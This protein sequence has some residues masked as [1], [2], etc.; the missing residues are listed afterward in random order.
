LRVSTERQERK[1]ESLLTQASQVEQ[2]VASLGGT[3]VKRYAGQEHATEGY[4]RALLDRLLSDAQKVPRVFDAVIVADATRWSRDNVRSDTGLE[5]LRD[6]GVKFFVL[7]TEYDLHNP[8]ARMFLRLTATIGG[9]H[10]AMQRKKSLENRIARAKRGL[11]TVGRLPYGRLFD[12][13]SQTWSLDPAKQALV[14][15]AARRYL[16]GEALPRLVD[17]VGLSQSRLYRLLGH[18][19]GDSW[20]LSFADKT[21]AIEEQVMLTIPPLLD[22][23][24]LRAVQQRLQANATYAHGQPKHDYLLAGHVFCSGCGANLCGTLAKG[25]Q[26]YY[27][28]S[29]RQRARTC[30]IT[31]RLW[32]NAARLE[33]AVIYQLANL[34]GNP[35]QI[36]R[37]VRAAVPDRVQEQQ[38]DEQLLA[39]LVKVTRGRQ[40]ILD[41]VSKDLLSDADA[42]NKL[43]ELKERQQ[44]L[45]RER[46]G[47][48]EALAQ[49]PTKEQVQYFVKKV[50]EDI[51]IY[52]AAGTR[53]VGGNDFFSRKMM[54][55]A[56][57]R[58]LVECCFGQPLPDGQPSGI[59]VAPAG[60][61]ARHRPRDYTWT[62][63]GLL[64]FE[65]VLHSLSDR[66]TGTPKHPERLSPL[67]T[68]PGLL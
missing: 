8:E 6:A 16:A 59:Y 14:Q 68:P 64:S 22:P 58:R 61:S 4:E 45:T 32:V 28:H 40:R 41:L 12:K 2:A 60:A 38:R 34:L 11:P 23:A 66:S 46:E 49:A 18:E 36:E 56:D 54:S 5:T 52:D 47:L 31:P 67:K 42:E 27:R 62:L 30:A 13:K 3:I 65:T 24:T 35:A 53:Y 50:E 17:L 51:G 63:R 39:E 7:N 48:A 37:V 20:E 26:R 9:Y 15:E 44:V 33:Q 1:G 55:H 29:C 57:K 25:G 21:L 10:A 19:C 43:K